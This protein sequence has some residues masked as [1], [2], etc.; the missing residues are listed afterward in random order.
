VSSSSFNPS[1]PSLHQTNNTSTQPANSHLHTQQP[2]TN[3]IQTT[4]TTANMKTFTTVAALNTLFLTT[5]AQY[6][7]LI[8]SRSAS[9]IHYQTVS[10]SNQ[11]LWLNKPT[12]SYCPPNIKDI[13]GCPAGNTTDFAGGDNTLG[14]GAVVPG[15]QQ[16]YIDAE[17]GAVKYTIAHSAAI[18]QGDIQTGWNLTEGESFG[19]LANEHGGFI[20]CPAENDS[21][22]VYVALECLE[23]DDACLG[24]SAIAS[25][26]TAA[27]AWQYT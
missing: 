18:P 13:G 16:V 25:N 4:K 12:A 24:F 10:A 6:F 27:A 21:W 1:I 9:P 20:A 19:Y 23:F 7:G 2:H 8:S 15:G 3:P 11:S 14:M 22:Q 5:S 17:T 26:S